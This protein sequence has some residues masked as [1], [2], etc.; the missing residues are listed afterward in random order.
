M[1]HSDPCLYQH[2]Q[3]MHSKITRPVAR[4]SVQPPR[5]QSPHDAWLK[6]R[7]STGD[8]RE[9]FNYNQHWL[10]QV[11]IESKVSFIVADLQFLG[12]RTEAIE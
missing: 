1:D 12:S 3:G 10:I 9:K 7:H 2:S 11:N 6:P 4:H 8:V 5:R